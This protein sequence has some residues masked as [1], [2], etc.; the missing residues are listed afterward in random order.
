MLATDLTHFIPEWVLDALEGEFFG[1][2]HGLLDAERLFA[3]AQLRKPLQE[4]RNA[5]T[6]IRLV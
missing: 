6:N 1:G 4:S 5:I 2:H 3:G